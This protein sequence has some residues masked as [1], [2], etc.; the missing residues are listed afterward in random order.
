MHA[1]TAVDLAISD[2]TLSELARIIRDPK[3]DA[4]VKT[5]RLEWLSAFASGFTVVPVSPAIA[6][7]A[8]DYAF[9]HRDPCDR[10]ILA[11]AHVLGLPLATIDVTLTGCARLVGVSVLW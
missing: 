4:Y 8:A 11:T 7:L 5:G 1:M 10:H 9:E 6:H 3:K 2:V